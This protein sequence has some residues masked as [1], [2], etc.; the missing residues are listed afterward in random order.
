MGR[1]GNLGYNH[2][3]MVKG[4]FGG[5]FSVVQGIK[6]TQGITLVA[7]AGDTCDFTSSS[8]CTLGNIETPIKVYGALGA[9]VPFIRCKPTS[10]YRSVYLS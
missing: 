2:L 4:A 7:F 8:R 1:E 5:S 3:K 9:P 10:N 6:G